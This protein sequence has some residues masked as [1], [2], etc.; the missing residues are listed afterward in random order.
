[1]LYLL[2]GKAHAYVYPRAGCK[3]WDTA[4]PEAVLK[5]AGGDLTD[6]RGNRYDYGKGNIKNPLNEYGVIATAP[7][8]NHIEFIKLISEIKINI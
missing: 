6:I 3:R 2:E 4:G 8:F 5:A 7:S 1:M